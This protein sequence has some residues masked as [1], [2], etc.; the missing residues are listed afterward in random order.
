[1]WRSLSLLLSPTTPLIRSQRILCHTHMIS[2]RSSAINA[3]MNEQARQIDKERVIT[4][5]DVRPVLACLILLSLFLFTRGLQTCFTQPMTKIEPA[6]AAAPQQPTATKCSALESSKTRE[7]EAA[8]YSLSM[9]AI[10][11]LGSANCPSTIPVYDVKKMYNRLSESKNSNNQLH[12]FA[13]IGD[14]GSALGWRKPRNK[15]R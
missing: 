6:H 15:Q 13:N 10:E 5:T 8:S 4:S 9:V 2:V 11:S 3:T 14:W 1:M 7:P 12:M